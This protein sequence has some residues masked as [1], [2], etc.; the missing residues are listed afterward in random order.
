MGAELS[1]KFLM[2]HDEPEFYKHFFKAERLLM[3]YHKEAF[4]AWLKLQQ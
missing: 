4:L 1:Y 3:E 2:S